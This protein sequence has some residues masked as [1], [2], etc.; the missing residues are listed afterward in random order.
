MGY[1]SW[2]KLLIHHGIP[3]LPNIPTTLHECARG[4]V[5]FVGEHGLQPGKPGWPGQGGRGGE[6]CG[7]HENHCA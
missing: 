5:L 3:E 2:A 7:P 6:L 1:G 4:A